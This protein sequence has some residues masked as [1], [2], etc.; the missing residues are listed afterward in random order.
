MISFYN[1]F[2]SIYKKKKILNL[3]SNFIIVVFFLFFYKS[4]FCKKKKNIFKYFIFCNNC[5]YCLEIFFLTNESL[6]Y[7]FFFNY[8]FDINLNIYKRKSN[9][10]LKCLVFTNFYNFLYTDLFIFDL[11]KKKNFFLFLGIKSI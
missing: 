11:L 1:F 5:K 4:F 8:F 9:N 10:N 6:F 3:T 2:F 7:K